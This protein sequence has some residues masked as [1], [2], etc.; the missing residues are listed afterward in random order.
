MISL[1]HLMQ[2]KQE[3]DL[4]NIDFSKDFDR[5]PYRKLVQLLEYWVYIPELLNVLKPT[6]QT[7]NK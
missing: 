6:F 7:E 1:R 4:S 2:S 5:V 3:V